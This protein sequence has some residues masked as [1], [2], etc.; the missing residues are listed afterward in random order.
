ME[1]KLLSVVWSSNR[2]NVWVAEYNEKKVLAKVLN[3]PLTEDLRSYYQRRAQIWMNIKH[4]HI[5]RLLEYDL[6]TS[7]F[8]IEYY[9]KFLD[10]I[11]AKRKVLP[12]GLAKG[13]TV[14]IARALIYAHEM[15]IVHGH[16]ST[17]D[18]FLDQMNQPKVLGWDEAILLL[19]DDNIIWSDL[20]VLAPELREGDISRIDERTDIYL[21]GLLLYRLIEGEN[22]DRG[23]FSRAPR[24]LRR[25]IMKC[26]R[27]NMDERYY[28]VDEFLWDI[29]A[30]PKPLEEPRRI[31]IP[32]KEMEQEGR[33]KENLEEL[34][35]DLGLASI[36][37]LKSRTGLDVGEIEGYLIVSDFAKKSNVEGFWYYKPYFENAVKKAEEILKNKGVINIDELAKQV[38]VHS[39]DLIQALEPLMLK[40]VRDGWFY[41]K[42]FIGSK[43]REIASKIK[44]EGRI[45]RDV[46]LGLSILPEDADK[47]L[48]KIGEKSP[49]VDGTYYSK[50]ILK[51]AKEKIKD[52][53]QSKW[54]ITIKHLAD[55]TGIYESDV[56]K[57]V[58]ELGYTA[59]DGVIGITQTVVNILKPLLNHQYNYIRISA[60]LGIGLAF[61][62]T[63]ER[64]LEALS[65]YL[66]HDN[67]YVRLSAAFGLG[68]AYRNSGNK[69]I[70]ALLR[71]LLLDKNIDIRIGS[72]FGIS[73]IF[74]GIGN[75]A[76]EFFE[77]LRDHDKWQVRA[78]TAIIMG[79]A[80]QGAESK[81]IDMIRPLLWD[82]NWNVRQAAA[83]GVGI[84]LQGTGREEAI[85][86][87]EPLLRDER[88]EIRLGAI[89][90]IALTFF[91]TGD[92]AP[93]G[94]YEKM[95]TDKSSDVRLAV[96]FCVG[97]LFS[98]KG[99][100]GLIFLEALLQERD[101]YIRMGASLGIAMAYKGV[102]E[103]SLYA[104]KRFL[105]HRSWYVRLG[106]T[107]G[108]SLAFQGHIDKGIVV[109]K[110][111]L[112][113]GDDYVK[114]G[115]AFGTGMIFQGTG[116]SRVDILEPLLSHRNNLIRLGSALGVGLSHIKSRNKPVSY[117]IL[118]YCLKKELFWFP[119]LT[120]WV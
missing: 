22:V 111:L 105:T 30:R 44:A 6:D 114:L 89:L 41:S 48:E 43:I 81:G 68:F 102:G 110:K 76:L 92:I 72:I 5:A 118:H 83:L 73:L 71:Q 120:I 46:C 42:E 78:A 13:L 77:P 29:R 21:L 117:G 8:I 84:A 18:I 87:L 113:H 107:L 32:K 112:E 79:F 49:T 115:A 40:S 58:R 59:T 1:V 52:L 31:E 108:I 100:E 34:L 63:R 116:E 23:V 26:M 19:E 103:K 11:M 74:Q 10:D 27:E 99:D 86:L 35:K 119:L 15:G 96:P 80:S 98:G 62:N 95:L 24:Y 85:E 65:G 70:Y 88:D 12:L 16:L 3:V 20:D 17:A 93:I 69:E 4:R 82:A 94:L 104:L 9:P 56:E 28:T 55:V 38:G 101:E 33:P 36:G 75:E 109:L 37:L 60:A 54:R 39:S 25:V 47:I 67:D 53:I 66:R 45:S 91:G 106:A 61:Q 14:K 64:G 57:L 2:W 51:K 97:L 7:N 90:G 50:G